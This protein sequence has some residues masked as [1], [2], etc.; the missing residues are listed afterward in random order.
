M[1]TPYTIATIIRHLGGSGLRGALVYTGARSLAYKCPQAEGECRPDRRA[2]VISDPTTPDITYGITYVDYQ[3]GLCFRVNGKRGQAWHIIITYEP[4][5]TYSVFLW[6]KKGVLA[7]RREVYCEDL[8][9]VV[10]STYDD[11]IR[12]F[13]D[14][15]IPL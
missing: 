14:G 5:D 13:N 15:F 9:S 3:V 12:K 7:A 8:K 2:R 10:E 1:A 4:N 6:S 11:A